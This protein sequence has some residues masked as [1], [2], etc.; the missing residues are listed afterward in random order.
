MNSSL[1]FHLCCP[2]EI[3]I[4]YSNKVSVDLAGGGVVGRVGPSG[5]SF[6]S[7]IVSKGDVG[8]LFYNAGR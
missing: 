2:T 7:E 5:L 8:C 6:Y 1:G 3:E 4:F